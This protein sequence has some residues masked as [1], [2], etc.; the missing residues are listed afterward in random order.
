MK[1]LDVNN[2]LSWVFFLQL[3]KTNLGSI[4]EKRTNTCYR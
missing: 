1:L 3:L 4:Y 2:I